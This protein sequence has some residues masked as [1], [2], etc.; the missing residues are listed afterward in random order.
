MEAV[1]VKQA[2][3]RTLEEVLETVARA[4]QSARS[5]DMTPPSRERMQPPTPEQVAKALTASGLERKEQE[6]SLA[7]LTK[8]AHQKAAVMALGALGAALRE[9]K[10][11]WSVVLQSSAVGTGKSRLA[12]SL[13]ADLCR[14]GMSVRVVPEVLLMAML[15]ATASP[16]CEFGLLQV[17]QRY[18]SVR[19][20]VLDDL[21]TDKPTEFY[22]REIYAILDWRKR[23]GLATV[24]TMN[25]TADSFAD[26][27]GEYGPRLVS[28][29]VEMCRGGETWITMEGPDLRLAVQP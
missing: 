10:D 4:R 19:V 6:F 29:I 8:H 26:R 12:L 13:A 20:L 9:G 22:G 5:A 28:R 21:G 25:G 3:T 2:L 24:L 27:C 11:A 15:R 23:K 1:P 16:D 7:H 14:I 17:R 18:A